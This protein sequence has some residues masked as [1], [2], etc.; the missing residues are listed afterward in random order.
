MAG[1]LSQVIV[2]FKTDLSA[3]KF[4]WLD[5]MHKQL[6]IF[7]NVSVEASAQKQLYEAGILE[8][9]EK[10]VMACK[11]TDAMQ[12]GIIERTF[13]LISKL[14]RHAPVAPKLAT[15]KHM[16]FKSI[17]Y[18]SKEFAGDLQQNALRVLYPLCKVEEFSKICFED[19]KFT[20]STFNNYVKE[21]I[22]LFK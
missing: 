7:I 8:E 16:V 20:R 14:L 6:A 10:V 17:L 2:D 18:M 5:M 4:D 12:R 3:K 21:I 9:L 15:Q 22:L 13:N 19:H 11:S 1:I